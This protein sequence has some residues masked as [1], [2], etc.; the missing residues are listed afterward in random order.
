MH[1]YITLPYITLQY[2]TLPYLTLHY[3]TLHTYI[4]IYAYTSVRVRDVCA[5]ARGFGSCLRYIRGFGFGYI[6]GY[7]LYPGFASRGFGFGSR[8][9]RMSALRLEAGS[10]LRGG[11]SRKAK[12]I[13]MCVHTCMCVYIY[14]CIYIY[15][16]IYMHI[17]IHIHMCIYIY[18]YIYIYT[19][20]CIS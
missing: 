18:I 17:H 5:L 10:D 15:I 13:H 9:W 1:T 14:I 2:I 8:L 3:I 11:T 7:A 19:Y 4:H 6:R 12:Y 20:T 16:Y